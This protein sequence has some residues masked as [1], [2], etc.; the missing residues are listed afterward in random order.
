MKKPKIRFA[1][2][3]E[4]YQPIP[5]ASL[6][7]FKNGIN[8]DGGKFGQGI[9]CISVLD[10]L[11][12]EFITYDS[13]RGKVTVEPAL[14]KLYAVHDGDVVFQRSSENRKD[15]GMAN[16]YVD[17]FRNAVF[18]GFVIRGKKKGTFN[19]RYLGYLLRSPTARK[20]ISTK[21]NGEIHVNVGQ[22]SLSQVIVHM[23]L[24]IAEQNKAASLFDYLTQKIALQRRKVELLKDS[25]K[26][27]LN[28]L[29]VRVLN[30]N[31]NQKTLLFSDI[32]SLSKER[33]P[34]ENAGECVCIEL[35][36]L[37]SG[38]GRR[39]GCTNAKLQS[40][41]KSVFSPND[42]LFGKLRPYL[43][44]YW[45]ADCAGICS[46]EIWVLKAEAVFPRYLYYLI[47]SEQFQMLANVSSGSKMPR[48]DWQYIADAEF[49]IP[50]ANDQENFIAV[51]SALEKKIS[52]S[53]DVLDRLLTLKTGFLQQ[54]FD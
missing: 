43:R 11:S 22:D 1:E 16:I 23:P 12:D 50:S 17:S 49:D 42:V 7:E 37:E 28:C 38:T 21:A 26:C 4:E 5:L 32:C 20:D 25:Y 27:I 46:T 53:Q 14:E 18:S 6:L 41:I 33:I 54:L 29:L 19:S 40:S 47:Q 51:M 31:E 3:I 13:I 35:E 44:K 36:H 52:I 48:S 30:E 9:K 45:L 2:Y 39:L 15:A 34:A 10:I 8:A 24:S